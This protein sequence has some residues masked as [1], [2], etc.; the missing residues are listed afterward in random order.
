MKNNIY[1]EQVGLLEVEQ[2]TTIDR[3]RYIKM[4][5]KYQEY[6]Q[7]SLEVTTGKRR[8]DELAKKTLNRITSY[9]KLLSEV[10]SK[11]TSFS[12]INTASNGKAISSLQGA[13]SSN[14]N[15]G[16]KGEGALAA[17][18]MGM[19]LG[20]LTLVGGIAGAAVSTT[21]GL[22]SLIECKSSSGVS[23]KEINEQLLMMLQTTI[24]ML[25][26]LNVS[27]ETI[28]NALLTTLDSVT[29]I[30]N[31]YG[32]DIDE[33][34]LAKLVQDECAEKISNSV[35]VDND[36]LRCQENVI[37]SI[38]EAAWEKMTDVSHTFIVD[39]EVLYEQLQSYSDFDYSAICLTASKALE[40]EVTRRYFLGYLEYLK[41]SRI[42]E[43][44]RGVLGKDYQELKAEEFMLGNITNITGYA[45]NEQGTTYL[46]GK[47]RDDSKVFLEYARRE[48]MICKNDAEC[49]N[50]I[51]NH[52]KVI[53]RV[54]EKYRNPSA[55]KTKMT[56]DAAKECLEYLVDVQ[57]ALGEILDD[58]KW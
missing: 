31:K 55:H 9:M 43:L 45:V 6:F 39:A 51:K 24:A 33:E 46:L 32:N 13:A 36:Y 3:R 4:L 28:A 19:A 2:L 35:A 56:F 49:I 27:E 20:P 8:S 40:V 29:E 54:R 57:R 47:F 42:K 37:K 38:G 17:G 5:S 50:K 23:D 22:K 18:G 52:V 14:P 1:V 11:C 25:T 30:K 10:A 48:L 16:D 7:H 41:K 26:K 15:V 12:E 53:N 34:E 44:P 58:C 21:A